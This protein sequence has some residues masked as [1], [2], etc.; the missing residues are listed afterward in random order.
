VYGGGCMDVTYAYET[1]PT[2]LSVTVGAGGA[3]GQCAGGGGGGSA[4]NGSAA[5]SGGAGGA[6]YAFVWELR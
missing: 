1:L 3:G 4:L 6:G 5:G 2:S